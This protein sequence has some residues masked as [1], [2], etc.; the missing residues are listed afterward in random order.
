MTNTPAATWVATL[1][2]LQMLV[3]AANYETWLRD[4]IGQPEKTVA[5]LTGVDPYEILTAEAALL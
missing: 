5:N 4:T 1:G 2:Q 3:T